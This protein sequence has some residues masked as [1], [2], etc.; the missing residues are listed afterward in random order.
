MTTAEPTASSPHVPAPGTP[1]RA[2]LQHRYGGPEVLEVGTRPLPEPG[3][4][5]VLVQVHAAGVD[6]GT[7]HLLRGEPAAAR[8]VFGLR[9]PRQPVPGL[10][11]AGTVAAVG[12]G[13]TRLHVGDEVFGIGKGSFAGWAAASEAKLWAKP[14]ALSWE[15]AAA[16]AVSG[17]TALQGLRDV[18]RLEAGQ[19]VLVLG[20]S[21]GVGSFA[22]QVAKAMGAEVTG[23][24]RTDKLDFVRSLGADHVVDHTRHEVAEPGERY[25]LVL[26][27][28]GA[29]PGRHL[30]AA[31]T[32]RGTLVLVGGEMGSLIGV[33]R[34]LRTIAVSPF[35]RQR[36]AMFISKETAD[37]L[38]PLAELAER[39]EL[40]PAVD[41]TYPLEQAADALRRLHAGEVRGKV[42]LRVR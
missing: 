41:R 20:A 26:V 23:T 14:A 40:V 9:L 16:T 17:L 37:D 39:G 15:Q 33:G 1:V 3:D 31:L 24:A 21:G 18:G 28:G 2:V 25:D 7:S 10:D 27:V 6:A 19:R 11:L 5:E 36:L 29:S 4:G 30:R 35:L 42:V 22:V 8:V 12:P 38:E 32:P 13:I 34:G